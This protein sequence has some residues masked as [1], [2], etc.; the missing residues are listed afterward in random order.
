MATENEPFEL[1]KLIL[2]Q[3]FLYLGEG[4][5]YNYAMTEV[6][7]FSIYSSIP[8][9]QI[10]INMVDDRLLLCVHGYDIRSRMKPSLAGEMFI[11]LKTWVGVL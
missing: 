4:G 9:D 3:Y 6:Q 11:V 8:I 10:Y 2:I 7:N 1:T 5:S